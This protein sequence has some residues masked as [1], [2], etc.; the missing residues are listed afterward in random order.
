MKQRV[1]TR[2]HKVKIARKMLTKSDR[3]NNSSMFLSDNWNKRKLARHKREVRKVY[4]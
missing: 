4:K 3:E 1:K 2:T